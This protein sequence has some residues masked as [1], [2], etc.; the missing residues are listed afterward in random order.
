MIPDSIHAA[1]GRAHDLRRTGHAKAAEVGYRQILRFVPYYE[2][3]ALSL[4]FMLREQGRLGSAG[5]VILDYWSAAERSPDHDLKAIKFLSECGRH[6]DARNIVEMAV[7]DYP[8]NAALMEQ[9]AVVA[10]ALGSFDEAARLY[11]LVLRIDP[12]RPG[13]WLRLANT[14]VYDEVESQEALAE[15]ERLLATSTGGELRA[16]LGFCKGK[17][18]DDIGRHAAACDAWRNANELVQGAAGFPAQKVHPVP[19]HRWRLAP[20][21]QAQDRAPLFLVGMPRSGTTLLSRLL[22][23]MG[24]VRE[25]G[26][27]GWLPEL[28]ARMGDSPSTDVLKQAREIYLQQLF[29]DDNPTRWYVDKNPLNYRHLAAVAALFPEAQVIFMHRSPRDVALSLWSQHFAHEDMRWSYRFEDIAAEMEH[30]LQALKDGRNLLGDRLC[31]VEYKD[32][33]VRPDSVIAELGA[34]LGTEEHKNQPA[35]D[36]AITTASVWQAR[37]PIYLTSLERWRRYQD[38]LPELA[39]F[40][41]R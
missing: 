4:A 15:M 5:K 34:W 26:E 32:L 20:P 11:R 3:A 13:A 36:G 19:S 40:D 39:G 16:A 17:I 24:D 1:C 18:L 28:L 8:G 2:E 12:Q 37:Q 35:A 9:A 14:H 38:Y 7:R 33:V 10:H 30:C 6:D 21:T 29:Q 41:P 22:A 31:V 25:R 27:L 23:R